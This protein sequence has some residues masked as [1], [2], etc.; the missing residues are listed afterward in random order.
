MTDS[1]LTDGVEGLLKMQTVDLSENPKITSKG[2]K[3]CSSTI[4]ADSSLQHLIYQ[5]GTITEA[6]ASALG[7]LLPFLTDLD[8]SQSKFEG[9]SLQISCP[10]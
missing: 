4:S 3:H 6:S 5:Q 10:K 8:L 9:G 1:K 7:E 2:W